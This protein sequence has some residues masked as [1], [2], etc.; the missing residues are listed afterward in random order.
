MW[1]S[2]DG[3]HEGWAVDFCLTRILGLF[4]AII[5]PVRP[6]VP[7]DVLRLTIAQRWIPKLSL[8]QSHQI[9]SSTKPK[10]LRNTWQITIS[11]PMTK[12]PYLKPIGGGAAV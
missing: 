10:V 12:A 11:F 3:S 5:R 4:L 2:F 8:I 7:I 9:W 6:G 1:V